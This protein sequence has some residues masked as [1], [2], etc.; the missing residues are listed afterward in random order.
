MLLIQAKMKKFLYVFFY[1]LVAGLI[2]FSLII[3]YYT[4]QIPDYNNLKKYTPPITTRLYSGDEKFLKEYAKEKRMFVPIDQIPDIV[5]NAFIVAEDATFYVNPG[6]S[7]KSIVSAGIESVWSILTGKGRVRGASTITQQV[8]KIFLLTNERTLTRKIKEAIL[9]IRITQAFSKS[10]ILELY[11][12]QI[13]FGNR[14]YGIASAA[15]NYFDKTV[16]EL[17]IEESALLASLPKAPS[18]LDPTRNIE[19]D[20]LLER[21]NWI[22]DRLNELGYITDLEKKKAI[23]TAIILK[24][25]DVEFVTNGEFFSEEV[26]KQLQKMYTE[27][28][29]L[30]NGYFVL[31]TINPPLQELAD[32]YLKEGIEEYDIRHGFRGGIV[33]IA[34]EIDFENRWP[35]LLKNYNI[36]QKYP[37]NWEKAVVLEINNEEEIIL[38]GLKKEEYVDGYNLEDNNFIKVSNDDKLI[39]TGY[40]PLSNLEWARTYVD[41]DTLGK[42]IKKVADVDLRVGDIIV[43][44]KSNVKNE[45]F[46]KQIPAVN[47]ALV[48]MDAHTGKILAMMGGYIDSQLDFNRVTQAERQPGSTIKPFAYL[49]ALENGWTPASMIIDEEITLFQGDDAPPYRPK[50]NEGEDVYYG[51]TTLRVGLEKSRNVTTVRLASE[52]GI[53]KIARTIKRFGI[54]D[55]PKAIYSLVLGSTETNLLKMVR[56]YGMIVNG[57]KIIEPIL[58]EKIQDRNGKTIFKRENKECKYCSVTDETTKLI[59]IIVPSLADTRTNVTDSAT[60]YQMTNLL[61]GVVQR[62]TGWR[63]KFINR[64]IGAKTGTTNDGKDAWFIGFSPDL[65]VGVYIGFDKPELLGKNEFGSNVAGPIFANFTRNALANTPSVPFRVPD[66]VKIVKI[67][68]TTGYYPSPNANPKNIVTE[69]FKLNEEPIKFQDRDTEK[70]INEL[71][72]MDE[73]GEMGGA[74]PEIV[75]SDDA[76]YMINQEEIDEFENEK[77]EIEYTTPNKTEIPKKSKK[78][79]KLM[80]GK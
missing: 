78:V 21:R 62:G 5:K 27:Q 64:P 76:T 2:S 36:E 38:I 13:F 44:K 16:D 67:D 7:V 45:Y 46:L 29:L 61:V 1:L 73:Y 25:K 47:G 11:L 58:I 71:E 4:K 77:Y 56:A 26:R 53:R 37:S 14:S 70:I 10:E 43:V 15:L 32:K 50:N 49:T 17:T 42:N 63:A 80:K 52:V 68:E 54:N 55:K 41:V 18:Q 66:T 3:L 9:A 34:T 8:A 60:A 39:I 59:D 23:E 48:A 30:E 6:V 75:I 65:V 72:N 22:I 19:N 57:G 51:P 40:I 33:N 20:A 74:Q 69:A 79:Y 24:Q 28:G 12:N 35:D 31:T